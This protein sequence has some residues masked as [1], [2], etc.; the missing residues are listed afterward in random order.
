MTYRYL[1]IILIVTLPS[2]ATIMTSRSSNLDI[3]SNAKNSKVQILDR[4]YNLPVKISI[5][6]SKYDLN[7]LLIS[8]TST[9]NYTLKSSPNPAFLFGNLLWLYGAPVAYLIDFTTPKRF[10]YGKSIA[11]DINDTIGI[12]RPPV[13]KFYHDYFSKTYPKNIGQINLMFSIP[14]INSFYL[15]PQNE[16]AKINTGFWGLSA[17]LEYFYKTNKYIGLNANVASDFFAP[18]PGAVDI[19]GEY[20]MM[21]STYFS[22]TDNYKYKRFNLGYGINYSKN[23]WDFRF[24][25]RFDPPP[26]TRDP[27]KKTNESIGLTLNGYFQFGKHFFLGVIYKP[28][29][30]VINPSVDL[31]YEHLISIDFAWKFRLKK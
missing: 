26:S 1:F 11:L 9:R 5:E 31:K 20:E 19:S 18:V 6:K 15:Q 12:L 30:L 16:T 3:Y 27:I 10:Y 17:G 4:T 28:T 29:I 13:S 25:D 7:I 22:I 23:T 21:S 14:W 24:Y 2:C 8:D